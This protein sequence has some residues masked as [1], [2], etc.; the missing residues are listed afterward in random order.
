MP[1]I[2]ASSLRMGEGDTIFHA[3]SCLGN[4]P[5]PAPTPS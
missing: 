5:S 1:G 4:S 3:A 2:H